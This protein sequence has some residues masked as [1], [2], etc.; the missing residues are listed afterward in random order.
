M[1][2][3]EEATIPVVDMSEFLRSGALGE[4]SVVASA[5]EVYGCFVVRD[6]RVETGL[7]DRFMSMMERYFAQSDGSRDARPELHYQVGVTTSFV[8]V[9]RN[10]CA[11][12]KTLRDAALSECPPTPDQ[13]WRFFW[14]IGERPTETAFEALNA[15]DVV[16]LGFEGEWEETMNGW[17]E[18]LVRT[19][20]AVSEMAAL[21]FGL[22]RKTFSSLLNKGP[23]LLAPTG[24]DLTKAQELYDSQKRIL[25]GFHADLNFLTVH[26]KSRY[27][28]L[29]IWRRD[30]RVVVPKVPE[31]HLLV[32]AGKQ[33][34][35][36]TGG[37][38]LAGYHEVV[39]S[40][41]TLKAANINKSKWR[42]SS[43]CFAH[44]ASDNILEPL[45]PGY[46]NDD[47]FPPMKA[48]HQV[49][50]ELRAIALAD[51]C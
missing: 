29:R 17:G 35:Y 7:N 24:S 47:K 4:C 44:V 16:P 1:A 22:D 10:H 40:D 2:E 41:E 37:K 30:G 31:G 21:G 23:H 11:L 48:G 39:I 49:Q 15:A 33:L 14:R 32:Q 46:K 45:I 42:V 50:Q 38:V 5:L 51:D 9:P 36:L 18:A 19:A 34:E 26:G 28:G 3:E 13:K 27:P 43:T 25:A 6:P 12:M 8:E 20:E